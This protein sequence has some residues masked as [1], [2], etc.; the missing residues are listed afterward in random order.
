MIA[1]SAYLVYGNPPRS[2]VD[3]PADAILYSPLLPGTIDLDSRELGSVSSA[4]IHAPAGTLERRYTFAQILQ[5]LAVGGSLTALALKDKGGNRIAEELQQ[6]GCEVTQTSRSHYRICTA[7]RP[8][9]L[10]YID[11]ALQQGG[12]RLDT[13]LSLWTQPGIFSWNRIDGGTALL[14]QH[15]PVFQGSGADLGCGLGVLSRA[16]LSS[17]KVKNILLTDIDRRAVKAAERN[18]TDPR[19]QFLW[20]DL[21]KDP[22]PISA[23]DFVIMNPPFHDRGMEDQAL[24]Q[25]FIEHAAELLK[26]GGT[27]WFVANQHLPYESLLTKLF[28]RSELIVERDGFKIYAAEK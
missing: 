22:L 21:R 2:L 4:V 12:M 25:S 28:S 16:V 20:A 27:C 9:T 18:I 15:M 14:L 23:L 24:G 6:F 11:E 7:H 1:S 5:K 10:R 19:A 3:W 13:E 17:P 26:K 8:A